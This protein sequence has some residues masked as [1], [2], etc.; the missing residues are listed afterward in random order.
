MPNISASRLKSKQWTIS[1]KDK[2]GHLQVIAKG[3]NYSKQARTQVHCELSPF[4]RKAAL[5]YFYQLARQ[6]RPFQENPF[7][8]VN[9]AEIFGSCFE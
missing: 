5:L 8:H 7:K 9:Y 6:A 3:P 4:E 1:I 2:D